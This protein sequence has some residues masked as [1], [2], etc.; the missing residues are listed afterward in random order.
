MQ[1]FG[2]M[3]MILLEGIVFGGTTSSKALT[4]QEILK[5]AIRVKD[6]NALKSLVVQEPAVFH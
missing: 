6:E 3:I 4:K 2:L 1:V 5:E